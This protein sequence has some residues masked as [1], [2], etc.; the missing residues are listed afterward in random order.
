MSELN[1]KSLEYIKNKYNKARE[2]KHHVFKKINIVEKISDTK[3][4]NYYDVYWIGA[5][6]ED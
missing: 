5:W 1:I 3:I 4:V 2:F 6:V